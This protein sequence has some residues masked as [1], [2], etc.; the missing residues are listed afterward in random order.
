M[1]VSELT[2]QL[3]KM[4][5]YYGDLETELAI[6]DRSGTY[7]RQ[8]PIIECRLARYPGQQEFIQVRA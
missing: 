8:H 4:Q 1:K 2:K 6:Q 5:E 3:T 7:I